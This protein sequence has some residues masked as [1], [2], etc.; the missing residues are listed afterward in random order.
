MEALG[1]RGCDL[2]LHAQDEKAVI[3]PSLSLGRVAVAAL[4]G[5][6]QWRSLGS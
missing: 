6:P 5:G 4:G 2:V 1:G 3:P